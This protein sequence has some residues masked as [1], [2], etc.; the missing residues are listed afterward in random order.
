M[1]VIVDTVF[2]ERQR[3]EKEQLRR[4]KVPDERSA[5]TSGNRLANTSRGYGRRM[6]SQSIDLSAYSMSAQY[7][8][9]LDR[10]VA[11]LGADDRVLALFAVGSVGRGEADA[12]SDLDL[13]A[14]V[15]DGETLG[16]ITG[17]W[18]AMLDTITPSVY[19][20]LLSGCI[21]TAVTPTW[22]RLDL[23][24]LPADVVA[25][26]SSGPATLLFS[27]HDTAAPAPP[28]AVVPTS[29]DLV[30]RAENFIRSVGLMVTDLLRGEHTVLTWASEFLINELVEVMFLQAGKPR[31][32]VKRI[33]VDLPAADR[34]V[35]EGL[36]RA[37]TD[38]AD[39]IASC[40]AVAN[41]YLPRIRL[42]IDAAANDEVSADESRGVWP[43]ELERATDAYL[44]S[45]LGV[46][47]ASFD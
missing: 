12:S 11:E 10:A 42:L 22:E 39:I 26:A 24:F 45:S 8:L 18:E 40:L 43:V 32:T 21:I 44:R 9:L 38:P 1:V 23:M 17:D 41:E 16:A 14:V 7:Q 3:V 19:R 4:P 34:D 30:E 31:R 20:R 6:H 29:M 47:F 28:T 46:G 37:T 36:P 13:L 27:R 5:T 33:Y 15:A 35:L 2:V 25:L